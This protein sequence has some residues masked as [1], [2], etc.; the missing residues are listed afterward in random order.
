MM[1]SYCSSLRQWQRTRVMNG[2]P[3]LKLL[4]TRSGHYEYNDVKFTVANN[5]GIIVRAV[6]VFL[7]FSHSSWWLI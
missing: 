3:R 7:L 2:F 5:K 1:F 4:H 6:N